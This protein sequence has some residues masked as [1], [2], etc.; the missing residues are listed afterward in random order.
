MAP[1]RPRRGSGGGDQP[2]RTGPPEVR[3]TIHRNGLVEFVDA[4]T[5]Q[6][7]TVMEG[8]T[9][10]TGGRVALGI[11]TIAVAV[12]C[13]YCLKRWLAPIGE[14][15]RGWTSCRH[16]GARLFLPPIK[17]PVVGEPADTQ[18]MPKIRGG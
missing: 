4:D 15:R 10:E 12:S 1:I 8:M 14:Y 13:G 3:R 7:V 5:G 2:L 9:V 17:E 18:D 16:C 6:S 11:V